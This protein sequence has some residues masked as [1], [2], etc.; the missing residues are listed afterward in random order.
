MATPDELQELR[1]FSPPTE[2]DDATLGALLDERGLNGALV[3]L[4][5]AHA[6]KTATLVDVSES[7]SSRKLSQA[8]ATANRMA[9]YYRGLLAAET[10]PDITLRA[11]STT[12]LITR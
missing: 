12:R 11:R 10:P 4:W 9:A 6:S 3:Y 1:D 2:T 5:D 7:G 8:S